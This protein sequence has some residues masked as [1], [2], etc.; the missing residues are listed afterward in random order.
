MLARPVFVGGAA[1][2]AGKSWMATAI[3]RYLR[4]RGLRVAPFKAQNMSNNS[5]PCPEGGEIGRAQVAQAEACGLAPHPDFN[6]ILLK[7]CGEMR[8]QVV[9]RGK[10]WRTLAAR[11]YYEHFDFLLQVVLDAYH[12][13]AARHDCIVIEGAGSIA[14]LNLRSRDLVNL[15]L[16][17]RLRAPV[18]LVAD[19]DRGGVFAAVAGTLALLDE[20][21]RALVRSFAINRFRGDPALFDGGVRILEE[22]TGRPCLGVFPFAE[23]IVLDAEDSTG[24]EQPPSAAWSGPRLA[25]I[26]FPRVSNTTDFQFLPGLRWLS[27]PAEEDCDFLFLPGS[28]STLADL[29][30]LRETGLADWVLRQH[31]RGATIVGVCGGYQMLGEEIEDPG[32]AESP[33]RSA[34]GLGL[35]PLRTVIGEEKRTRAVRARTPAGA[36]FS[37]YEI[38]MGVSRALRA[39]PPFAV[40]EDGTA[41]GM[42]GERCLG[43]YL[44]GALECAALVEELLGCPVPPRPPREAIYDRLGDWFCAHG[45]LPLFEKLYL[46]S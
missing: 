24:L 35:L 10:V 42:R 32:Q 31:A 33:L 40:L 1:S 25:A 13:L 34:Q 2:Q 6:P 29:R 22:R 44:H 27:R 36:E 26:H 21:E 12:R 38:H 8:S 17:S 39:L 9:V 18:L 5:Y 16:A 23:D 14:E 20:S 46:A 45:D 7:P 11:E 37:A 43:T 19:I 4:G 41:E 30:W 15:G 3:C 28:K